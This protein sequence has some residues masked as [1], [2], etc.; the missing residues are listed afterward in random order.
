DS[1]RDEVNHDGVRVLTIYPGRTASAMQ[2]E[3]HRLEGEPYEPEHLIQ[4][5]DVASLVLACVCLPRTAEVTDLTV[6]PMRA[7]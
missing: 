2:R 1:L 7:P 6:R 5:R 4:P 3:I